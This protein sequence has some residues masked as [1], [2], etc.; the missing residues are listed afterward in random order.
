M[1]RNQQITSVCPLF[2]HCLLSKVVILC[3]FEI[4]FS[5]ASRIH[6]MR[7]STFHFLL[8]TPKKNCLPPP[9]PHLSRIDLLSRPQNR[10]Q[11]QRRQQQQQPPRWQHNMQIYE[12]PSGSSVFGIITFLLVCFFVRFFG[13]VSAARILKFISFLFLFCCLWR[14]NWSLFRAASSC[15]VVVNNSLALRAISRKMSS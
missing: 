4:L 10:R 11:R 8:G 9:V 3:I 13:F 6:Y 12:S 15:A 7:I 5:R 2:M 14:A 1:L